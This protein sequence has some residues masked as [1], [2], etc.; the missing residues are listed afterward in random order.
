MRLKVLSTG[1]TA[2]RRY[3]AWI[4]G[5]ILASLVCHLILSDF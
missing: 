3:G 2:E 1:S 4:G 5:S